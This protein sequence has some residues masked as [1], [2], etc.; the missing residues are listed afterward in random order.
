MASSKF[1]RDLLHNA[2]ALVELAEVVEQEAGRNHGLGYSESTGDIRFAHLL[3]QALIRDAGLE[4]RAETLLEDIGSGELAYALMRWFKGGCPRF[5]LSHGLTTQLALTD[6]VGVP[7]DHVRQ[8]FPVYV[9]ELPSPNGPIAWPPEQDAHGID[10]A[11]IF[12]NTGVYAANPDDTFPGGRNLAD[13]KMLDG[14]DALRRGTVMVPRMSVVLFNWHPHVVAHDIHHMSSELI[15]IANKS[16]DDGLEHDETH[17]VMAVR[18][19]YNLALHLKHNPSS[20]SS[21]GKTVNHDHGLR[22]LLY[23]LGRDVVLN[24]QLRDT[25]RSA[26]VS[27]RDPQRWILQKRFI[28]RGHW[29]QQAHGP[30]RADRKLIFVEPYWKGPADTPVVTR[31]Y[32]DKVT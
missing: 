9:I 3:L 10:P 23:E 14:L 6:P 17:I 1:E 27:G 26:C 12:V 18:L 16:V 24:K 7:R 25:A 30:G 32:I 20:S 15:E 29:K 28:V 4:A 11:Y 21:G 22:S 5:R 13:P 2:Q 31:A 8:P 19:A